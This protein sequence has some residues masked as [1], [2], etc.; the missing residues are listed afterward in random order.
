M[1]TLLDPADLIGRAGLGDLRATYIRYKPGTSCVIGLI[2]PDGA[3]GALA[4]MTYPPVRYAEVRARAKWQL[5]PEPVHYLDDICTALVPLRHDRKVVAARRLGSAEQRQDYLR[6]LRLDGATLELLR[7]KPGRRLVLRAELPSGQAAVVK[8]YEKSG[9]ASALAGARHAD[10][11]A[12]AGL[13]SVDDDR[14][15]IASRWVVGTP[16]DPAR[17]PADAFRAAGRELARLHM[18]A[19]C[20]GSVLPAAKI[21]PP[22]AA[23][24][25][26]HVSGAMSAL[27]AAVAEELRCFAPTP[28]IIHGD[29]SA[30]QV[31]IQDGQ[32]TVI[33]WDRMAIGDP[34]R[35]LGTFQARLDLDLIRGTVGTETAGIAAVAFL[36]G[37]AELRGSVPD[38]LS[39]HRAAALLAL[40]TEGFRDRRPDWAHETE[41][42]LSLVESLLPRKASK[43][44]SM[45]LDLSSALDTA[46]MA[47]KLAAVLD[48]PEDS[49]LRA[50][51]LRHKPGRRALIRY[52]MVG[53]PPVICKLRAKGAD[54]RTP[55][56]HQCLRAAGLDGRTPRGV[57]VPDLVAE[58]ETPPI[59]LQ[60]MVAG[61]PLTEL[62]TTHRSVHAS[63][64]TGDA[65]ATLHRTR[66]PT[67]REW[68]LNHELDVIDRALDHAVAT[69]PDLRRGIEGIRRSAHALV[70]TLQSADTTGIHRDFYPDQVLIDGEVVWL[71]DLDLY[72]TGDPMIDVGNFQAH[73]TELGLRD[74]ADPRRFAAEMAAFLAGY[75]ERRGPIDRDRLRTL[76]WASLIRH[77]GIGQ[78]IA[79]RAHTTDRLVAICAGGP[80]EPAFSI[81]DLDAQPAA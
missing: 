15:A 43:P 58:I 23:H 55:R 71:V 74:H 21:G 27:A 75:E 42:V 34:A 80:D 69:R 62:L 46:E 13:L 77:I 41:T 32:A 11:Y 22:A 2:P 39:S 6:D 29:F 28:C 9:F 31:V 49:V 12:G 53:A 67:D 81:P 3:L 72:A 36:Q 76:H 4:A 79:G 78:R 66:I 30:D 56:L 1:A 24:L 70:G 17:S 59:W 60:Q 63:G 51:L 45:T 73:L 38:G 19:P 44:P 7:Y 52:D 35:D 54:R 5:G 50:C 18:A 64:R 48:V 57:G 47:P 20:L 61:H 37:Y 14:Y 16:L 40:A 8:A 65:L 33:D 26:R 68:A 25:L 10:R